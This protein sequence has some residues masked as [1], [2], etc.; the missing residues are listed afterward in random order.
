MALVHKPLASNA[1]EP[2]FLQTLFPAM[3]P[4][5][6]RWTSVDF[7]LKQRTLTFIACYF[8]DGL[9]LSSKQNQNILRQLSLFI[10]SL[11]SPVI[12]AADWQ[13]TPEQLLSNP[14]FKHMQLEVVIPQGSSWSCRS[15]RM[16]DFFAV[17]P[18]IRKLVLDS[19]FSSNSPFA[20]HRGICLDL[21]GTFNEVVCWQL[22]R[23]KP[24]PPMTGAFWNNLWALACL[25]AVRLAE[26]FGLAGVGGR[27]RLDS[28]PDTVA[29]PNLRE[30]QLQLSRD[31]AQVSLQ[32]E[33]YHLLAAEVPKRDWKP[34]LG[35]GQFPKPVLRKAL[36]KTPRQTD[37]HAKFAACGRLLNKLWPP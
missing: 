8:F 20:S 2:M 10:G 14:L 19:F 26:G 28:L 33:C 4:E 29:P 31:Y 17:P 18:S 27:P 6:F 9:D 35:R 23:P 37:M 3:L 36:P 15:G 32:I 13:N 12:I 24:L 22:A 7:R 16:I 25:N 34:Y 30:H 5:D 11:S 1:T 21:A